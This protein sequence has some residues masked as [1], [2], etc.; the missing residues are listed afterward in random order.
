MSGSRTAR[1]QTVGPSGRSGGK[2][3]GGKNAFQ[4]PGEKLIDE[5]KGFRSE[6]DAGLTEPTRSRARGQ[7]RCD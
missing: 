7:K 3:G 4:N 5:A 1:R 6:F 2:D